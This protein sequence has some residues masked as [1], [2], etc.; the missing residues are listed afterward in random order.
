M[1]DTFENGGYARLL[2]PLLETTSQD[3]CFSGK[4]IDAALPSLWDNIPYSSVFLQ[5]R[6]NTFAHSE[7]DFGTFIW[8]AW[9]TRLISEL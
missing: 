8:S 6:P 7:V 4:C 1:L 9:G 3:L 5:A 2:S